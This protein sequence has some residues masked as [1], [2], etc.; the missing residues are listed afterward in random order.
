MVVSL[1]PTHFVVLTTD[2]GDMIHLYLAET[3]V[4]GGWDAAKRGSARADTRGEADAVH[5]EGLKLGAI[6]QPVGEFWHKDN[7]HVY[8]NEWR[9]I[10]GADPKMFALIS[11]HEPGDHF[12]TDGVHVYA[13]VS[14]GVA[15]P[16]ADSKTFVVTNIF[17]A[18]GA[19]HTYEWSGGELKIDGTP[20][21]AKADD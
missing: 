15:I 18:K 5:L 14:R 9:L 2:P 12:A 4:A 13:Y 7:A 20:A 11:E 21:R 10:P 6:G 19:H 16:G 3:I 1:D 17:S 8:T